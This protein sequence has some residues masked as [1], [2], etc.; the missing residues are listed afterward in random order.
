MTP[1]FD[2]H[3]LAPEIIITAV[4]LI[5]LVVDLIWRE[6]ARNVVPQIAGIGMLLALIPVL[7]LA[8]DGTT[9]SMFDGAF[10]VDNFSLAFT[11]FF[12]VVG[13]VTLL[14]SYDYIAEGDYY[15]G[16]Y[17]V[18]ILTSVLGM[19]V[20]ASARDLIS[21]FVALET[22]TLPTFIL[23]GWRKT[24]ARIYAPYFTCCLAEGYLSGDRPTE[25]LAPLAEMIAMVER[26]GEGWWQP[27]LYRLTGEVLRKAPQVAGNGEDPEYF[28]R[29][30]LQLATKQGAQSLALRATM[31]LCRCWGHQGVKR[32]KARES[33]ETIYRAFDEGLS[34]RDLRVALLMLQELS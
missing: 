23:A 5:V 11:G 34:T 3:A 14:L 15:Q 19:M 28:F 22:I 21:I 1:Y 12:L 32:T 18:L 8:A 9:R 24:G 26:T 27:E 25:G 31:S 7:T 17:Y 29:K 30:A 6:S 16:E 13:Y 2:Y 33:L 20:M 4:A 10:V